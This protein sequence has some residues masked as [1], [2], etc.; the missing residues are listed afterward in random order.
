MLIPNL[1]FKKG[2]IVRLQSGGPRMMVHWIK[3]DLVGCEWLD[4]TE[5][6]SEILVHLLEKVDETSWKRMY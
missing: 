5:K 6:K 2:D 3:G 4:R 1:K